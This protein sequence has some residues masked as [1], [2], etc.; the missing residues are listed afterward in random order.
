MKLEDIPRLATLFEAQNGAAI[1][2]KIKELDRKERIALAL[3][4]FQVT[5]TLFAS[6]LSDPIKKNFNNL[7][8]MLRHLVFDEIYNA[9]RRLQKAPEKWQEKLKVLREIPLFAP[10][11]T[12]DLMRIAV[13]VEEEFFQ[14]GEEILTEGAPATRVFFMKEKAKVFLK[15]QSQPEAIR[16]GIFGEES[17]LM[18]Q[19]NAS[20]TVCTTEDCTVYY[21]PSKQFLAHIQ[22]IP[23]LQTRVFQLVVGRAKLEQEVAMKEKVHAEEQ[24]QFT[25]QVLDNIGQGSFSINQAGE[26]GNFSLVA[27]DYLGRKAL[28]GVP[29]ADIILRKDRKA[30]REYYRALNML[31]GKNEFDPDLI[32]SLLPGEATIK[33][34]IFKLHY[35]FV[36]DDLGY[37]TSV[38]VRMEEVT[39]ELQLAERELRDQR[40]QE[41]MQQNIGGFLNMLENIEATHHSIDQFAENYVE[42]HKQPDSDAIG[43]L[44]RTLHGSKGLSGQF[45]IHTLKDVLHEIED[46]LRKIDENGL[47]LYTEEFDQLLMKLQNEYSHAL[48]FRENLGHEIT[49]ILQGVSF[50]Q[51]EY[52]GMLAGVLQRDFAALRPY[53]LAKAHVPAQEIVANWEA[54]IQRLAETLKKKID[55]KLEVEENLQVP[56]EMAKVLNIELGHVYRN[57]VDHGVETLQERQ[58]LGKKETGTIQVKIYKQ[59]PHL[60]L[61]IT[62]DGAGLDQQKI[63]ELAKQHPN[64]PQTEVEQHIAEGKTWKILFMSGFSSAEKVTKL[65]GRGVGL[66][67]AQTAIQRLD[68]QIVMA[69]EPGK[70]SAFLVKILLNP[71]LDF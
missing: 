62:D 9:N 53:I 32:L 30:L 38:F 7:G 61:W 10:S 15:S 60:L 66:D 5:Q 31:F 16:S 35:S 36:Q 22:S 71:A 12:F 47:E 49:Q 40:V 41:K 55:F 28:A 48:S 64:L 52:Q 18:E 39:L 43:E 29:F 51:E 3:E 19:E 6:V 42:S 56:K 54:D 67:A 8:E 57:S 20:A 25:Q 14:A 63:Q 11:S 59:S 23:E 4:G 33:N 69:S 21:I 24:R 70:G 17:C 37:V 44:M 65:S 46:C 45:E 34:R 2:N 1:E 13:D 27:Q 50:T 26:I 58:A 68:G